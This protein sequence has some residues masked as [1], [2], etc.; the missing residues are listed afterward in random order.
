MGYRLSENEYYL[1]P[2][3][4]SR[5]SF[6]RKAIVEKRGNISYLYSYG[7]KVAEINWDKTGNEK[8][9]IHGFYSNT[10]TRHIK[11]FIYQAGLPCGSTNEL[12]EMYTEAGRE[13]AA[14]K[15]KK[16]EERAIRKAEREKLEAE[17]AVRRA[18]REERRLEKLEAR[19]ERLRKSIRKELGDSFSDSEIERL[20]LTEIMA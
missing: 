16:A 12:W 1:E 14:E 17:K 3:Y 10:T 13:A 20:V 6:Y 2:Q 9:V 7:T 8:C 5:N 15:A 18:E 4:D 11:D 19:K